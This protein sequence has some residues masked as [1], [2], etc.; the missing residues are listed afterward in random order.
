[1]TATTTTSAA[2]APVEQP[3]MSS[4]DI[5]M[6]FVHEYYTF[7]NKDPARLHCFYSANSTLS[8]G[9]QGEETE[10]FSGQ[11]AIK[12]KIVSLGFEDCKVLVTNVDCQE[13]IQGSIIIQVLGDLSN[14]GGPAQK[15]VQTFFLAVQPK[16]FY[17]LNDIFRYLKDDS[18][19]TIEENLTE[20]PKTDEHTADVPVQPET[21]VE[22]ESA[23][24]A[25]PIAPEAI[26][27]EAPAATIVAPAAP[28]IKEQP[29]QT[30]NT[31]ASAANDEKKQ[32]TD[33]K[34]KVDRKKDVKKDAKKDQESGDKKEETA[35][36]QLTAATADAHSSTAAPTPAVAPATAPVETPKPD[37]PKTWANLAAKNST[38]WGAAK[39][40][41]TAAVQAAPNVT[42]VAP[43]S[44][45]AP[46]PA[47]ASTTTPVKAPAATKSFHGDKPRVEFHSI[48]IKNVTDRM[49]LDQIRTAF[50]KFGSVKHLEY[51]RVRNCVFLDFTTPEAVLAALKQRDVLVGTENVLAEERHRKSNGFQNNNRPYHNNNNSSNSNSSNNNNSSHQHNHH[52]NQHNQHNHGNQQNGT[53]NAAHIPRSEQKP[54]ANGHQHPLGGQRGRGGSHRG[55]GAF[56]SRPE[57]V[58]TPVTV[59]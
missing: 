3:T 36:P 13:S 25:A 41:L 44:A 18:E 38:Q 45:P 8:H 1:M 27:A 5:G 11:K 35:A 12:S 43:A 57:N 55:R 21:H 47:P 33:K 4:S 22:A 39:S 7:L 53:M 10:V 15:F 23:P 50:N 56:H 24:E 9:Y 54:F 6:I 46:A 14:K 42:P 49:T 28:V 30:V 48:Y 59:K 16:G 17:V 19:D 58:G 51:A 34:K 52:H 2:T 37:A 40:T 20:D 29:A 32:Q 26:T 31:E